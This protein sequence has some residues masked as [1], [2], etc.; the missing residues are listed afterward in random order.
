MEGAFKV[1]QL[2]KTRNEIIQT[3]KHAAQNEQIPFSVFKMTGICFPE[4]LEKKQNNELDTSEDEAK[5]D[6]A[7]KRVGSICREAF[8]HNVRVL[9]DA[10][11]SWYQ[12][13][14]DEIALKMMKSY[15]KE[16]AIVFNTFQM[17]RKDGLH[18][19]QEA[20]EHAKVHGYI[21]GIKLVRGAYL[22]KEHE[23]AKE[24]G[25]PSPLNTD[26]FRSDDAFN[27]ALELCLKNI[28]A[29]E[30]FAGTHNEYSCY[31]LANLMRVYELEHNDNRIWFS[32]LYG[33]GDHI[34]FNLAEEGFN[35]AKYVPYGKVR[36][37]MPYLFRRAKEN[38]SVADQASREYTLLQWEMKRRGLQ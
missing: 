29:I 11:E 1:D 16:K 17:Y 2:D 25:Y 36:Y 9:I 26:K 24:N 28:G 38:T 15:N 33:M 13:A 21:L 4:I 14:I 7:V 3:I 37:V 22:E 18:K 23:M 12:D 34:S 10:E 32:Q 27:D 35:V 31:Y 19:L 20:I 8:D 6:R 30:L 5:Y